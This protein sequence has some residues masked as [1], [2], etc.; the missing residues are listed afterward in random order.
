M[1][2]FGYA[3]SAEE[4]RPREQEG[5]FRFYEREVLPKPNGGS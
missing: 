1:T 4:L 3:L 2:R 5:F